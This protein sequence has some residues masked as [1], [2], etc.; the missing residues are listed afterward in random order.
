VQEVA[1]TICVITCFRGICSCYQGVEGK[2]RCCCER[3]KRRERGRRGGGGRESQS[4]EEEN[5]IACGQ[6]ALGE[7]LLFF[8]QIKKL[9]AEI[10]KWLKMEKELVGLIQD[11]SLTKNTFVITHE[12]FL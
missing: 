4:Q 2:E 12:S 1:L 7:I 3:E 9:V 8:A 5:A 11:A 10:S 6:H